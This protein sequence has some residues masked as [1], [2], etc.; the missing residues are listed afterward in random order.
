MRPLRR[1]I[2]AGDFARDHRRP[3]LALGQIVGRIHFLDFQK[4]EQVVLLFF[5]TSSHLLFQVGWAWQGQQFPRSCFQDSPAPRPFR[6]IQCLAFHSH[7][8]LQQP[9]AP[10]PATRWDGLPPLARWP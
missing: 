7:G 6:R 9:S 2:A 8:F 5:Q 1:F 10:P 3:Q 4:G